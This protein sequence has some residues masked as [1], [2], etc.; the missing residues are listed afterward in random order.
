MLF[1]VYP[2]AEPGLS[3]AEPVEA[4]RDCVCRFDASTGSATGR[5][6][7]TERSEKDNFSSRNIKFFCTF[8]AKGGTVCRAAGF[9]SRVRKVRTGQGALL[10]KAQMGA[11]S[12]HT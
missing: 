10:G 6:E 4:Y 7:R 1:T 3:V 9:R 12:W 11:I 2:V 5:S 8:A